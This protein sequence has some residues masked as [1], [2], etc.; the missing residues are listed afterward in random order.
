MVPITVDNSARMDPNDLQRLLHECLN[1]KDDQGNPAPRAVYA[2][3][4]IVGSTEHSA[5][6]P[7]KDILDVRDEV[8]AFSIVSKRRS[9]TLSTQ[10]QRKGLSFVLHADGAWGAYFATT[11]PEIIV[12]DSLRLSS[13]FDNNRM[14]LVEYNKAR[15]NIFVPTVP[16][17][18]KTLEGI[19]HMR[20]CDSITVDPHKSGYI[21]YPAGGLL[22]R[23]EC[24]R[25]LVTWTSP[26]VYCNDLQSIGVFGVKG[27]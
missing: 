19:V 21:Q 22:Y 5:C 20:D 6:D 14:N 2:V 23:D 8:N 1:L 10:F 18:T 13:E 25:Y 24:M 27:R 26:I 3:V 11:I 7:L 12:Q 9:L 4:A 15:L 17:N 16:L